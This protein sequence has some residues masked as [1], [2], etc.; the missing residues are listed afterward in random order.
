MPN[1]PKVSVLMP[2]YNDLEYIA[3]A[4]SSVLAQRYE[5]WE[6]IIV[7]D[8]STD[9]TQKTVENFDDRRIKYL[10]QENSGLL[11]ALLRGTEQA[12]GEY[13]TLLASDDELLDDVFERNIRFLETHDC[14]GVFSD[15]I[16]MDKNGVITGKVDTA[17]KITSHSP[18]ILFLRGGSNLIP[19][20]FFVKREAFKSIFFHFILWNMPYWLKIGE[21]EIDVLK[22]EKV[23]PW[24]K[25]RVYSENYVRSDVGKFE[26]SNGCIRT[27]VE[28][29]QKIDT[30][31]IKLQQLLIR[32]SFIPR[33]FFERH[34]GSARHLKQ[35]IKYTINR[36]YKNTPDN[37]YFRGVIGFFENFPSERTI[38]MRLSDHDPVFYGKDA[39]IFYHLMIEKRLPSVYQ[40][41]L[42]E[43]SKGFS[44]VIVENEESS[45]KA[46]I[47]L[48]M[49]NLPAKVK[50]R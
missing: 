16:K 43:A 40:Y 5:N 36:Y 6:L 20:I 18:A 34:P 9:N 22:L 25:Y 28:I 41:L 3:S 10:R 32:L 47:I 23:K 42:E 14:D 48:K 7:D 19:D 46:Q 38:G 33:P 35:A 8:G 26:T 4:I 11:N 1:E 13:I 2:T 12:Q 21:T 24:Y 17:R 45:Q 49:L 50:I 39:R 29:A 30:P 27:V 44:E 31:F 37:I 15:L